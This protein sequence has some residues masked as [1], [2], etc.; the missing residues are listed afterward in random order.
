MR[1]LFTHHVPVDFIRNAER[2]YT[3]HPLSLA[4]MIDKSDRDWRWMMRR[5]SRRVLMYTEMITAPAIIRGNRDRLLS[6]DPEEKPLVLQLGWDEAGLLAEACRIAE[7]YGY[8][9]I[10]LNCGCPSDKVQSHDFG[11][12]LMARP[13]HVAR[14]VEAMSEATRVPITVKNRIGIRS[15][16]KSLILDSYED[17][18]RFVETVSGAGCV[19]FVVHARTA[20]LEGLSPRENREV[21]PLRPGDV[22]RLKADFPHLFIEINGGY[23][24]HQAV[25]EALKHVDA[26]MLGRIALDQPW[27][28]SQADRRWFGSGEPEKS[29]REVI[30]ACLPYIIRRSGEGASRSGLLQPL[31]NLLAGQRGAREWKRLLA[32]LPPVPPGDF[33]SALEKVLAQSF[34]RLPALAT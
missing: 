20:I 5:I 34:E 1:G 4:P 31:M 26:V 30:E 9:E 10:N 33:P 29:R 32:S 21:P 27:L 18:C 6:F 11:A 13:D 25:D 28:L 15:P 19:K 22:Y 23:R 24:T 2:G 7:D 8:D 14:L 16:E 12:C 17:L 3:K